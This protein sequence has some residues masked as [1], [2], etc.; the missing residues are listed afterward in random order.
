MCIIQHTYLI[1]ISGSNITFY[2]LL[3]EFF[4]LL[5]IED[6][7]IYIYSSNWLGLSYHSLRQSFSFF[8]VPLMSFVV[9]SSVV[10]F[11]LNVCNLL[12]HPLLAVSNSILSTMPFK[13]FRFNMRP[14]NLHRLHRYSFRFL[15]TISLF[16]VRF[17]LSFVHVTKIFFFFSVSLWRC[18]CCRTFTLVLVS[19][20][21]HLH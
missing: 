3:S 18:W 15:C 19:I 8:F 9:F 10:S 7:Y 1:R 4:V 21:Q 16:L 17:I 14:H 5:S 13:S 12:C 20:P 6:I 11:L 2:H